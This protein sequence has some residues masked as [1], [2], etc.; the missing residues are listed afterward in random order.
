MPPFYP[1]HMI[2]S[3]FSASLSQMYRKEVPL[4]GTLLSL[5]ANT[6]QMTLQAYP[7]LHTSLTTTGELNRLSEERHGAI[8]VGTAN[9]L[10]TLKQMFALM[11]MHPV[12]YYDLSTAGIPVH[13]TAFRPIT[14]KE[15]EK[16]PFRVFTSL[17]RLELVKDQK[18]RDLATDILGKRNIFTEE[19][20]ELIEKGGRKGGLDEKDAKRFVQGAIETFRWHSEA[21]ISKAEYESL[22]KE[23]KLLADIVAFKG[24]HINHLTPRTLDINLVQESMAE[25]GMAPKEIIEGPPTRSC[26]ILLRQTS[27]K[28]LEEPIIFKNAEGKL[29]KGSHTAR[30][31]EV[32]ARGAALT[33]KGRGL[34]DEC[35]NS[36]RTKSANSTAPSADQTINAAHDLFLQQHFKSFPDDW[37]AIR[38]QGLAYFRYFVNP[39]KK[40][41]TSKYHD[42]VELT[43]L[44]RHGLVCYEPLVYEDFLPISAAGIFQSNLSGNGGEA[45]LK[46]DSVEKDSARSAFA[47]ALEADPLDEMKLYAKIQEESIERCQVA[48]GVEIIH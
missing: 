19:T 21:S 34:Y 2:R 29:E 47:D 30:F 7:A 26:P 23:H 16:S 1:P 42:H 10:R 12:A 4:Y 35:L 36:S 13:S 25:N 44:L 22:A 18:L 11:E 41:D 31:G 38:E 14:Q 27:F 9:E 46:K 24:P 5:V 20:L 48:L 8:R 28:A 17:L 3:A 39:N 33:P 40:L 37:E 15:L 6:N 32:E 45:V 43:F